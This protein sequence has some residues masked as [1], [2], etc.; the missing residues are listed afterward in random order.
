MRRFPPMQVI[1][2][3]RI[4]RYT[5]AILTIPVSNTIR[6]FFS[7]IMRKGNI[8]IRMT[9]RVSIPCTSSFFRNVL[10]S[11]TSCPLINETRVRICKIPLTRFR[12]SRRNIP[13]RLVTSIRRFFRT[14]NNSLITNRTTTNTR[15]FTFTMRIIR[16]RT[17]RLFVHF[18]MM[19]RRSL[20]CYL[21]FKGTNFMTV[22]NGRMRRKT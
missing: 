8:Q 11:A 18:T 7:K 10:S 13:T 21:F 19:I 12:F 15:T 9:Y 14:R 2:K 5:S 3:S 4:N 6:V 1:T 17:R 22:P 16:N 20:A